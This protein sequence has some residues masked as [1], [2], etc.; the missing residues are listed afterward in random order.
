MSN[1]YLDKLDKEVEQRRIRF[2]R[3]VDDMLM[4][5][6]SEM[7]ANRVMKLISDW[8]ERKLFL[9]VNAIKIKVVRPVR[10]KYL[11]FT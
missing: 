8:L 5:T 1:I 11:G 2:T 9:K 4:F 10:S 7:S 3:Y 6:R